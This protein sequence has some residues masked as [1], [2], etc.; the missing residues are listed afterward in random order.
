MEGWIGQAVKLEEIYLLVEESAAGS[1]SS[2]ASSQAPLQP[3]S[4]RLHFMA[5]VQGSAVTA[6]HHWNNSS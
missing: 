5:I 1:W 2:Q 4:S 6:T 3:A